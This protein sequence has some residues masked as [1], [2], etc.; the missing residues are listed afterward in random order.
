MAWHATPVPG[1]APDRRG[2]ALPRITR[3]GMARGTTQAVDD[4]L[5]WDACGRSWRLHTTHLG[6][7]APEEEEG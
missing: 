2:G 5:R 7:S 4:S 6:A 3:L 1:K